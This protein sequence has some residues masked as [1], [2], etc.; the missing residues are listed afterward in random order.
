MYGF[1]V[2]DYNFQGVVLYRS[3]AQ[4]AVF[5]AARAAGLLRLVSD[6]TWGSLASQPDLVVESECFL[7]EVSVLS[8][9]V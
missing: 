4:A 2:V 6:A 7:K 9:L 5:V 1:V 3:I 8:R